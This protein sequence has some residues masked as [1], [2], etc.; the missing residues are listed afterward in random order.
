MASLSLGEINE[1]ICI[2]GVYIYICL[3]G[4]LYY[5]SK[6]KGTAETNGVCKVV[7]ETQG[8]IKSVGEGKCLIQNQAVSSFQ[9]GRLVLY[10]HYI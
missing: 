6:V 2:Y 9:A 3:Y 7:R 4:V 10:E 8:R 1:G 5:V